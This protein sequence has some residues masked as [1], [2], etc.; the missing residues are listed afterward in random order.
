MSIAWTSW[1]RTLS[2]DEVT[3]IFV[4]VNSLGAKLG[5]RPRAGP[6]S[7]RSGRGALKTFQAFQEQCAKAGFRSGILQ[8][9]EK[10]RDW[11]SQSRVLEVELP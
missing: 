11:A 6:R 4:R 10:F 7:Q 2:Y 3:E 5:V 8:T 1:K 9:R